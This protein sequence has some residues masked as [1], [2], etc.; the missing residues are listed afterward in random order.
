MCG[1]AE[2]DAAADDRRHLGRRP[3]AAD[4]HTS[5]ACWWWDVGRLENQNIL[6]IF[7]GA[8]VGDRNTSPGSFVASDKN[9]ANTKVSPS[10]VSGGWAFRLATEMT[11]DFGW[12][13][14]CLETS[15]SD[16]NDW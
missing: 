5:A 7:N 8:R 6:K 1:A 12:R 3:V 10:S 9:I 15:G 11:G 13:Q 4:R 16:R 2:R 14:K